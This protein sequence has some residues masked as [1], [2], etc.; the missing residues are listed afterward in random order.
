MRPSAFHQRR[1]YNILTVIF[2]HG[3]SVSIRLTSIK[4]MPYG[5]LFACYTSTCVYLGSV[6]FSNLFVGWM[7]HLALL[8]SITRD[9]VMHGRPYSQPQC[10]RVDSYLLVLALTCFL[11]LAY[12]SPLYSLLFCIGTWQAYSSMP[13]LVL[14]D[15]MYL[16]SSLY[17]RYVML[18]LPVNHAC[19]LAHF[20]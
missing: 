1:T 2:K 20:S 6:S 14:S 17:A 19:S 15:Y 13:I 9:R 5:H 4:L 18:G 16:A 12:S 10:I 8:L 7:S 11:L 3:L